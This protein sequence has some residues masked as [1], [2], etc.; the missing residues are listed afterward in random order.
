MAAHDNTN[1][2]SYSMDEGRTWVPFEFTKEDAK[3]TVKKIIYNPFNP[4]AHEVILETATAGGE[5][6]IY[7]LDF[8]GLAPDCKG[9]ANPQVLWSAGW[10]WS[11]AARREGRPL[12]SPT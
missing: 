12:H 4:T 8:S 2:V 6:R 10:G 5:G 1:V 11:G 7:R 3:V 9:L